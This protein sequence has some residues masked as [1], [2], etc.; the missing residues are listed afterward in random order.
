M[1]RSDLDKATALNQESREIQDNLAFLTHNPSITGFE[2]TIPPDTEGIDPN[3]FRRMVPAVGL[4]YPPQMITAIEQQL[5]ARYAEI[6]RQLA[7]LGVTA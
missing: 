6:V 2:L 1:E 3:G 7:E 5:E 4:A